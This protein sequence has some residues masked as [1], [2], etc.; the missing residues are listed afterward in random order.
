VTA[1]EAQL[2]FAADFA[3]VL[4][5]GSGLALLAVRPLLLV[6]ADRARTVVAAGF[7]LLVAAAFASGGDFVDVDAAALVAVR[8]V[9]VACLL[10]A[11]LRWPGSTVGRIG[12]AVG[13][14]ALLG[15]ELAGVADVDAAADGLR[16]LAAAAMATGIVVAARR[17]IPTRIAAS[18]SATLLLVVLAVS[19]AL[20]AVLADN[21][22]DEAR[23]RLDDTAT[24]EAALAEESGRTAEFNASLTASALAADAAAAATI[25]GLVDAP[26]EAGRLALVETLEQFADE[27]LIDAD[28]RL[29][30]IL[31]LADDAAG[32]RRLAVAVPE[33]AAAPSEAVL[34]GIQGSEVVVA[35]AAA[36]DPV[37]SV[38]AAGDA[39]LAVAAAPI[40]P[41]T[42]TSRSVL[43]LLVVT[44]RLDQSYVDARL[45]LGATTDDG[46][47]LALVTR[48]GAIVAGS[49]GAAPADAADLAADAI[50]GGRTVV[51]AA[52]DR[53]V[54]AHPVLGTDGVP[55]LAVV[56]TT[57]IAA[58]QDARADLFRLLFLIAIGG[59]LL[60][61]VLTAVVGER[62]GAGLQRLT[63]AAGE[64]QAGDLTVE[65]GIRSDDEVGVL[66]HAFDSMTGS[67]R[68]MTDEL[69]AAAED[70][71]RLRA[72]MEAVVGGMGEALVAVDA[73]GVVTDFNPAAELLT[74]VPARKAIGRPVDQVVRAVA[75]DGT[76][77]SS[78]LGQP[79]EE[80]WVASATVV[81]TTGLEVPVAVSAGSLRSPQD[82][83]TG[84]VFLLR[85]VRREREVDRIKS[86]L[87]SN[88]SH[89]LRTPLSPIKGYSQ[90]LRARQL[91][92]DE[93]RRFANEIEKASARLERVVVQLV[94]FASMSAGAYEVRTEPALVREV[95]DR[96]VA[97]WAERLDPAVHPIAR[98]LGRR[99]PKVW[100]DRV[101]IDQA[102]DEL[103]DNAVKYSPS[104]GRIDVAAAAAYHP[105][106]GPTVRVSVTDRGVG[107][108]AD[109]RD[110]V[111]EEFTQAD[112]SATRSY[113]G[114]GLGLALVGRIVRAHGGELEL[115]SVEGKGTTLTMVLPVGAEG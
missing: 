61:L 54:A 32:P 55:V 42:G 89:E 23:R 4:V 27:R 47:G 86:E 111:L 6:A 29:G 80:G 43:G 50:D 11:P 37:Q 76:D 52:G 95:V 38:V 97:R 91:P 46:E 12:F 70:E 104:G 94:N 73:A 69:R 31:V 18:A 51:R 112:G 48:A 62:I 56:A 71:A 66:S 83:V 102:L 8:L 57:P 107:I 114:L 36:D 105:M 81:H 77:L 2:R 39:A 40:E 96:A 1:A 59:T 28:P 33:A 14:V 44:S 72:R 87:L 78:R 64:V 20:S 30:P 41:R 98:K 53:L 110:V 75:D 60:A 26:T 16:L 85:D 63:A 9:A 74:G 92:P 109:R 84:G 108:P 58:I 5:A 90:I 34:A 49:G 88:I 21:V 106:L 67:L 22:E 68:R 115:V 15:G 7:G 45:A 103:L 65:S 24:T 101:A 100:L 79:A 3:L 19:V 35:A 25:Q 113:G 10:V 13:L 93:V 82:E 17:S 99:L